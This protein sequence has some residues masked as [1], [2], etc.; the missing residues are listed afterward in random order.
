MVDILVSMLSFTALAKMKRN[1]SFF[2]KWHA[3]HLLLFFVSPSFFFTSLPTWSY[4]QTQKL[5]YVP[6]ILLF[7]IFIFQKSWSVFQSHWFYFHP[8]HALSNL[9]AYGFCSNYSKESFLW[10]IFS[11][12]PDPVIYQILN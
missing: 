1:L 2:F 8:S 6:D 10:N 12:S 7:L 5:L 9:T 11:Y 3:Y 4:F